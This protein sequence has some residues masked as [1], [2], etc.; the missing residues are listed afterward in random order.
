M[1]VSQPDNVRQMPNSRRELQTLE[2]PGGAILANPGKDVFMVV[3]AEQ[4]AIS[5]QAILSAS[6]FYHLQLLF[7]DL[8]GM[9]ISRRPNIRASR[10]K[11]PAPRQ[12]TEAAM[13][14][15]KTA[16]AGV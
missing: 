7:G 15:D 3:P 1:A 13:T 10:D 8:T 2:Y 6:G 12:M 5:K 9:M 4:Q 11:A 16:V 14:A